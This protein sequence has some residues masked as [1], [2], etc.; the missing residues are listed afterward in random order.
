M[1]ETPACFFSGD[2]KSSLQ[3]ELV[4]AFFFQH[5]SESEQPEID[6]LLV[7]TLTPKRDQKHNH[8]A[9]IKRLHH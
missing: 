9:S 2:D 5:L 1:E 8:R 3:Q 7:S 6:A 4:Q